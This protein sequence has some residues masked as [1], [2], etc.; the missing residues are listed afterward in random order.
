MQKQNEG[1]ASAVTSAQASPTSKSPVHEC[2]EVDD[3]HDLPQDIVPALI[4]KVSLRESACPSEL[5]RK[6]RGEIEGDN[7][8][9]TETSFQTEEMMKGTMT[10]NM[11]K[12]VPS[13]KSSRNLRPQHT[14]VLKRRATNMFETEEPANNVDHNQAVSSDIDMHRLRGPDQGYQVGLEDLTAELADKIMG[15]SQTAVRI[16]EKFEVLMKRFDEQ[17]K[18]VK[19]LVE[20]R[21]QKVRFETRGVLTEQL[22]L[23]EANYENNETAQ[24]KTRNLVEN[25]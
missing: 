4:E 21:M 2:I 17:K 3:V 23:L 16:F 15:N 25:I 13:K 9:I 24:T 5:E 19:D 1:D 10:L 11:E 7:I 14:E 20:E 18:E 8:K 6:A 12:K 22:H